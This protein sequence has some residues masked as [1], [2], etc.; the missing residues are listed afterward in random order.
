MNKY[1]VFLKSTETPV[2]VEAD[3]YFY[4]S[5]SQTVFYA[6]DDGEE[7]ARFDTKNVKEIK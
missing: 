6:G 3:R 4:E 5:G 7:V 2:P 1:E